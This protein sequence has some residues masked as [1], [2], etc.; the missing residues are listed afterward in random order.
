ML[1]IFQLFGVGQPRPTSQ[2]HKE[3]HGLFFQIIPFLS[4]FICFLFLSLGRDK[5][6]QGSLGGWVGGSV[7]GRG[8]DHNNI[9]GSKE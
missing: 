8:H 5:V 7:G 9:P 2:W 4:S 1:F 3:Q 6:I